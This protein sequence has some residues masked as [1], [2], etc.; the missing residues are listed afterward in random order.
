MAS[1]EYSCTRNIQSIN[2]K[3]L[4]SV[5]ASAPRAK[6]FMS[7]SSTINKAID[8]DFHLL[9]FLGM[10]SNHSSNGLQGW[11]RWSR[12]VWR[13]TMSRLKYPNDWRMKICTGIHL[14]IL[15]PGTLSDHPAGQDR[16]SRFHVP[17][18]PISLFNSYISLVHTDNMKSIQTVLQP[19]QQ[20]GSQTSSSTHCQ[21]LDLTLNP[22]PQDTGRK[23]QEQ[24]RERN[25][26][27]GVFGHL[28]LAAGL[29][30]F[31]LLV[32]VGVCVTDIST[33]EGCNV[34]G[35]DVDGFIFK[36]KRFSKWHADLPRGAPNS[37]RRSSVE[38]KLRNQTKCQF[39]HHVAF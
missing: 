8:V 16:C 26:T 32:D 21:S 14:N 22:E 29:A 35:K 12:S 23:M 34:H 19:E 13:S 38:W 28:L 27:V 37:F 17:L 18:R 24:L 31:S 9:T 3:C 15:Y 36:R 33:G 39:L 30:V 5:G 4:R 20:Q 11:E 2:W 25:I 7:H 10:I 6:F 1:D